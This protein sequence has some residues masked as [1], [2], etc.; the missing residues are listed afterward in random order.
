MFCHVMGRNGTLYWPTA[1]LLSQG[2]WLSIEKGLYHFL[3]KGL[4]L[5]RIIINAF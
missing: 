1:T 5:S 3:I 4:Y 2:I